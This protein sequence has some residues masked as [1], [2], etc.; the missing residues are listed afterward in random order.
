MNGYYTKELLDTEKKERL[1]DNI[2][3]VIWSALGILVVGIP[4]IFSLLH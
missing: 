2:N 1:H 3:L 4:I